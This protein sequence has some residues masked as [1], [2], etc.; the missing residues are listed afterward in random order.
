VETYPKSRELTCELDEDRDT[1]RG[2]VFVD[3][4]SFDA[5]ILQDQ[6]FV[7]ASVDIT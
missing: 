4:D 3:E 1:F 6:Y 5:A 7:H 2:A